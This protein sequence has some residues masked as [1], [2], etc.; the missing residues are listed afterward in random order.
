[1]LWQCGSAFVSDL[2]DADGVWKA[3]PKAANAHIEARY[4]EPIGDDKL[5][6]KPAAV[7]YN[8]DV[9]VMGVHIN[10]EKMAQTTK[11]SKFRTP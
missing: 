3:F 7:T 8:T 1:M 11:M 10:F 4:K 9:G 6:H 2:Y 5:G